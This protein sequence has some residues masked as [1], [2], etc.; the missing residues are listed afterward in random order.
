[1]TPSVNPL[2][3]ERPQAVRYAAWF[4]DARWPLK[5]VATLFDLDPAQLIDALDPPSAEVRA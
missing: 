4:L 1:V 3:T 5:S 2:L